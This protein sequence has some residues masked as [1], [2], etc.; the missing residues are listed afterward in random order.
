ML[1]FTKIISAKKLKKDQKLEF[2]V[3]VFL[4]TFSVGERGES[5]VSEYDA[6]LSLGRVHPSPFTGHTHQPLCNLSNVMLSISCPPSSFSKCSPVLYVHILHLSVST[7]IFLS[8]RAFYLL[9]FQQAYHMHHVRIK[10]NVNKEELC[11]RAVY[12]SN[13]LGG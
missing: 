11:C 13:E 3:N 1:F 12:I 6:R 5:P 7:S 4:F 10:S 9:D 8:P 2:L